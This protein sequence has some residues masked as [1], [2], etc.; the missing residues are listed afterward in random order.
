MSVDVTRLDCCAVAEIDQLAD[1]GRGTFMELMDEWDKS[2]FNGAFFIFTDNHHYD[3]GKKFAAYLRRH[4]LGT[5]KTVGTRKNPNS[6]NVVTVWV[7]MFNRDK[8]LKHKNKI[9][10]I[11]I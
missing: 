10:R 4:K 1:T 3:C 2:Y 8:C 6:G 7:W 9:G 11:D 5:V